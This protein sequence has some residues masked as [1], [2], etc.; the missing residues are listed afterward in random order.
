MDDGEW[1]SDVDEWVRDDDDDEW[2]MKMNEWV[3]DEDERVREGEWVVNEWVMMM[4]E[5]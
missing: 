1:V 4:G 5:W 3:S 2:G